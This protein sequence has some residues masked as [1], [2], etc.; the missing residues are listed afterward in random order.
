MHRIPFFEQYLKKGGRIFIAYSKPENGVDVMA[1]S[2]ALEKLEELERKY[3]NFYITQMDP[4]HFKYVWVRGAAEG[5]WFYSGSFNI[6][7]FF[8]KKGLTKVRQ[9]MMTKLDWGDEEDN[10]FKK[11]LSLFGNKY[12]E[13]SRNS[14]NSIKL[15]GVQIDCTN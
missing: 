15:N 9:E 1:D 13:Q 8:V 2:E 11:V 6:L 10:Y 3:Q 12:L 5:D 7:S 4:F 14:I